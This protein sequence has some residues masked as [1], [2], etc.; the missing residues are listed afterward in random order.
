MASPRTRVELY[1]TARFESE[2][3]AVVFAPGRL[4][5]L[6]EHLDHQGGTVLA[7]AL[8][9][10][11]H[12]AV[13]IRP[14]RRVVV[15]ALNVRATDTFDLDRLIH[16]GRRWADLVRGAFAHLQQDGRRLPG[17]NLAI[18]GDLPVEEGL[19]SSAAYLVA[20]LR[21]ISEMTGTAVEVPALA[22]AAQLVEREWA[23]V[24]CGMMDPL[25]SLVGRPGEVLRLDMRTLEHEVLPLAEGLRFEPVATGIQRRLDR[26]PYNERRRT[27][28]E[29][30]AHLRRDRPNLDHLVDLEEAD[31]VWAEARLEP[32]AFRRVRH[33]VTETARVGSGI[34]AR[35]HG[36]GP[37][38]GRLLNESHASLRD[39]FECSTPDIDRQVEAVLGEDGVLGARLQGAGWGGS[40]VVL[41][42][43]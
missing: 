22:E 35:E 9:Q 20:V 21:A 39:D 14:D 15:H 28:D 30:L 11:V 4:V 41:R 32:V 25:V 5:V 36:D 18:L 29:A 1:F 27:L 10:G 8:D 2:P 13:G 33:V 31:L 23:G 42:R 12:V 37:A 7:T 38:L 34:D 6:G 40:L 19:A 3:R 17:L 43:R 26:T 16:S 24:A